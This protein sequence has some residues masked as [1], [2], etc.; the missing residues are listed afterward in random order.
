M[1]EYHEGVVVIIPKLARVTADGVEPGVQSI[2]RT[3]KQPTNGDRLLGFYR[4]A[5]RGQ[6]RSPKPSRSCLRA[7]PT[8]MTESW[9]ESGVG[10]LETLCDVR[11]S[12]AIGG[13]ADIEQSALGKLDLCVHALA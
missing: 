3:F 7:V 6:G 4:C 2:V 12:I 9:R 1:T 13:K 10:T 5:T 11:C 8:L